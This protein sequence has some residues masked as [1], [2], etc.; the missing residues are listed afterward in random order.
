[1]PCNPTIVIFGASGD[2]TSRKLVPALYQ[3]FRKE[4][5]PERDADR[6]LLADARS[7]HDAVARKLAESTARVHRASDFDAERLATASRQRIYYQPATSSNRT[8]SPR[9]PSCSTSWR[10]DGRRP[11]VYYLATA[12][13][14]YEPA[15]AQLGAA[16][17]A[18]EVDGPRRDRHRK[19]LRH[20]PGHGPAS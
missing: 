12:P 1:M 2:L 13:Q 15:V 9:W 16:G 20:R 19:A 11:A 6:R 7:S 18:D 4:R 14:F 17:L 10:R 5:L 8:I 3:L